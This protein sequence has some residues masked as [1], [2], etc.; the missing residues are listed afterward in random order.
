MGNK[1]NDLENLPKDDLKNFYTV[2]LIQHIGDQDQLETI[3][4]L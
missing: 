1:K 4:L 3:K 2:L